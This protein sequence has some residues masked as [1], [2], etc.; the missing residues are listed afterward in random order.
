MGACGGKLRSFLDDHTPIVLITRVVPDTV[1]TGKVEVIYVAIW[2][3]AEAD[4][5]ACWQRQI[6][7]KHVKRIY[8]L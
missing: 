4:K 8:F 1:P 5:I 3:L 2:V 7:S 6:L